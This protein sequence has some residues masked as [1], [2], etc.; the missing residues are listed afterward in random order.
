MGRWNNSV[1]K[2]NYLL[3]PKVN[4]FKP[5]NTGESPLAKAEDWIW[6]V[7]EDGMRRRERK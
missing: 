6:V 3:L 4:D 5:T 2:M 7:R 1:L